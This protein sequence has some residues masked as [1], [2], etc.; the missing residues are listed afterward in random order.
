MKQKQLFAGLHIPVISI[1]VIVDVFPGNSLAHPYAFHFHGHLT[2][3]SLARHIAN[4]NLMKGV[5]INTS[6]N[7][8]R[9]TNKYV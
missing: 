9:H 3:D 2:S 4:S 8:I 6:G 1:H 7:Y 5:T